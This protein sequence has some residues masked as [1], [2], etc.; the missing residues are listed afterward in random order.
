MT[1]QGLPAE[2][3]SFV[4]RRHELAQTRRMLSSCRLLTVTGL[5]GVGK[6]RLALRTAADLRRTFPDGVRFLALATLADP[7]LLAH[8]LANAVGLDETSRDPLAD[9]ADH[10]AGKRLLLVLDNCEHLAEACAVLSSKLLAAAPGLRILAT[11]RH[12][13][14]VEGEQLLTLGPLSVPE[15]EV[16]PTPNEATRYEAVALF[17]ERARAAVPD[18]ELSRSNLAAVLELCRRLEGIPLAIELAV[19]WLRSLSPAQ[20]L[21]RLEDR[22]QLLTTSR[23]TEPHNHHRALEA[24]IGWSFDLCSSMEQTAWCRLS[25]FSGGF[26]IDAAEAVCPGDGIE[27]VD[28]L[29]LVASLVDKSVITRRLATEQ[30]RTWYEMNE[31]IRQ[32]GARHLA[33]TPGAERAARLRHREHYRTL[34]ARFG[35]E[36]FGAD[37][38]QWLSRLNREHANLR[39]ALDFSLTESEQPEAAL[40]LAAHL[41]KFWL[42]GHLLEG[43]R[44]ITQ[45]LERVRQPTP[46]R[47]FALY[48]ASVLAS[49]AGEA[50]L[51]SIL[52][53]ECHALA[54]RFDDELLRAKI[55]QCRGHGEIRAGRP[56]AAIAALEESLAGFESAGD[57][58]GEFDTLILLTVALVVVADARA[59][60]CGQRALRIAEDHAA[61]DS[62]ARGHWVLGIARWRAGQFTAATRSLR[63]AVS[64]W[65]P[66]EDTTGLASALMALSWCASSASPDEHAAR[67]LGATHTALQASGAALAQPGPSAEFDQRSA[68]SV[69]KALGDE[70]YA[71]AY[72]EGTALTLSQG[73]A[74]ALGEDRRE[75]LGP[76]RSDN[77]DV[78]TP[79]ETQVAALLHEG[80]S[81][82]AIAERLVIS[83]RTA[84][85]HVEH[86]LLKLGFTSRAQVAGWF[87]DQRNDPSSSAR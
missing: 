15:E 39:S 45:A 12:V 11:S 58:Q 23:I 53:E 79:R 55:L 68:D 33:S 14:G 27:P 54:D 60:A 75:D 50:D 18:F 30:T 52:L 61:A 41:L 5:G 82:R 66:L 47:A 26:D 7:S 48:D 38:A 36:S 70:R 67:L 8:T 49:V 73:L 80:L 77:N 76:S 85:T 34:A 78:L 24:T 35:N 62:I 2:L 42:T 40:D 4:G 51:A 86:I 10:L 37:Q 17:L 84:E 72:A 28:A 22:F 56:S 32:Y 21:D 31:A 43:L 65:R 6:T 9:L 71:R 1:E 46:R 16:R 81:N 20:V 64:I 69:R 87:S 63:E 74:L 44:Y 19:V 25:V 29:M 83:Q 3:T 59:E 13:L 57:A